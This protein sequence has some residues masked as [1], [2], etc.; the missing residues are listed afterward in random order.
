[1]SRI[2]R[3]HHEIKEHG[4]TV[5]STYT[6]LIVNDHVRFSIPEQYPFKPPTLW[7]HGFPHEQYL[8]QQYNQR[9]SLIRLRKYTIP[10]I[11]CSTILCSWCPCFQC[12]DVYKEYVEYTQRLRYVD[13]LEWLT[14]DPLIIEQI[15]TFLL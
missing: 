3:L 13:T 7:V 10:C 6:E 14:F 11:C 4:W 9:L 12:K 8:K 5:N 2:K 1:M 15:S